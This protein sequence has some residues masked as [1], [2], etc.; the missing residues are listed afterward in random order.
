M[1]GINNQT[2]PQLRSAFSLMEMIVASLIISV[3]MVAMGSVVMVSAR[4]VEGAD[5]S[6]V[7]AKADWTLA[8]MAS[9]LRFALSYSDITSRG[10]TALVPDRDNDGVLEI[11]R[12]EWLGTSE[13]PKPLTRR[14]NN[15]P[16]TKVLDGVHS[17][18]FNSLIRNLNLTPSTEVAPPNP[19]DW[20]YFSSDHSGG[21]II[22]EEYVEEFESI[23]TN[24]ITIK[25]PSGTNTS[26][27]LIATVTTTS[28][29]TSSLNAPTGWNLLVV[30]QRYDQVTTGVW[31][32][33]ASSLEPSHYD[34]IWSGNE[35]AY[36][37]IMRFTGH[38][39]SR[40]I[41]DWTLQ[42]T[43]GDL[44]LNPPSPAVTTTVDN[45]MIL[46]L[47]GFDDGDV[48]VGNPGLP[49]H[50]AITMERSNSGSKTCSSGGGYMLQ[51]KAGDSGSS[52]FTLTDQEQTVAVT[53]AITP[54]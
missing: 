19:T 35:Q 13:N 36:G 15:G 26:D 32:K 27:L 30:E 21:G 43:S 50:T 46:R 54:H 11:I 20:G 14:Y 25:A 47:G 48:T 3:L 24:R 51:P 2:Y 42:T 34:F 17:F 37:W 10:I 41:D 45:A 4:A 18:S 33:I 6:A 5:S 22:L 40:P 12:Y 29:K 8:K 31:W 16:I 44:T 49:G 7:R 1:K 28:D 53:I 23:G 38:D 52:T 39:L 9:E